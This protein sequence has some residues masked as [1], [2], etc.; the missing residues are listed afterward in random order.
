MSPSIREIAAA[1]GASAEGDLDLRITRA[2]EPATAGP[3]ALALAMD[4]K[5]AD[6]IAKG[7][8]RAALLWQGADWRAMGLE[9]AIFAPRSRLAMAG[10]SRMLDP[11]PIIAPGT[12][13]L[14]AI[15]PSA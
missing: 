12:H 1:L 9:A 2:S 7:Q 13:P 6:G 4:P 11:G 5:F 14:C 3:D 8:A 15:A 10:L